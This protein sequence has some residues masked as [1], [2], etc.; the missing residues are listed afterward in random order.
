MRYVCPLCENP[1]MTEDENLYTCPNCDEIFAID[2]LFEEYDIKGSCGCS[3]H[4][5]SNHQCGCK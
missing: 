4:D 3:S 5:N 2:D 1:L